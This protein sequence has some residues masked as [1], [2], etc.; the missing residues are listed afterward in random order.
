MNRQ[1]GRQKRKGGGGGEG[2]T[3]M[4]RGSEEGQTNWCETWAIFNTSE[5]LLCLCTADGKRVSVSAAAKQEILLERCDLIPKHETSSVHPHVMA[6]SN[7]VQFRSR[8]RDT[9]G[10]YLCGCNYH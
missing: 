10:H 5:R 6:D 7:Q 9:H 1:G 4:G 2:E 8:N 3:G